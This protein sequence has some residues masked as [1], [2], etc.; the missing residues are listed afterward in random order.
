[1]RPAA[2]CENVKA[3]W[4]LDALSLMQR[5]AREERCVDIILFFL[6]HRGVML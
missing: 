6:Y 5:R 1:M 3:N 4:I 2:V